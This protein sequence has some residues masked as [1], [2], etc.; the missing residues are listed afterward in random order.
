MKDAGE[1]ADEFLIFLVTKFTFRRQ[2]CQMTRRV[3]MIR[4]VDKIMISA[5]G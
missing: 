5:V 1:T 2:P 3:G 4:I